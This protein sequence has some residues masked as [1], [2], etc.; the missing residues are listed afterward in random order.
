MMRRLL[1]IS[2]AWFAAGLLVGSLRIEVGQAQ[3]VVVVEA[4]FLDGSTFGG[5]FW[6][7]YDRDRLV[8]V[9]EIGRTRTRSGQDLLIARIRR[10]RLHADTTLTDPETAPF[11]FTVGSV[12][13]VFGATLEPVWL[14]DAAWGDDNLDGWP[15]IVVTGSTSLEPPYQPHTALYRNLPLGPEQA[16]RFLWPIETELPDAYGGSVAWGDCDNDGDSD[17]LLTGID[18]N[19]TYFSEIYVNAGDDRFLARGQDLTGVAHGDAAWADYDNDMDLDL[20]L[21]GMTSTGAFYIGVLDNDGRCTLTE[22]TS[23]L[24]GLAFSSVDWGDVDSDG[25][26]DLLVAGARRSPLLA[27]AVTRI[28]RNDAGVLI[29]LQRDFAEPTFFGNARFADHDNDGELDVVT[30]GLMPFFS[31][32]IASTQLYSNEGGELL[33]ATNDCFSCEPLPNVAFGSVS[34]VDLDGDDDLDVFL[35]G[36]ESDG[37]IAATLFKNNVNNRGRPDIPLDEFPDPLNYPPKTVTGLSAAVEEDRVVLS[38]QPGAD[39]LLAPPAGMTRPAGLTYNLRVGSVQGRGDIMSPLSLDSGKR[40]IVA[41]GNAGSNH[42]WRI[43][44]LQPGRYYWSVQAI[45]HSYAGSP[46]AAEQSFVVP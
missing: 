35:T 15:D 39:S 16:D 28:F 6:A 34:F 31:D 41:I 3:P 20:V 23:S 37:S 1:T 36:E 27:D 19:G 42:S 17:L 12:I 26:L 46:F 13:P 14:A 44:G 22:S 18:E 45:D 8:D 40:L 10:N 5:S 33:P 11:V 4:K 25:D 24:P 43:V 2:T 9:A 21:S 30:T 7:D 38:W 29:D 32:S